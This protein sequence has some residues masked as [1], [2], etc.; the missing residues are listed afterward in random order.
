[1]SGTLVVAD[2]VEG[3]LAPST[4]H[5][6]SAAI[7]LGRP[8][9]L[10]VMS[11][12][13]EIP[14]NASYEGVDLI[15]RA[16]AANDRFDSE[17]A[18]ST[19]HQ[20]IDDT[21]ATVIMLAYSI[22]SATF[23]AAVAEKL[24]LSFASDVVAVTREDNGSLVAIRPVYAGKVHA[25]L[26]M[27]PDAPALL[28]LRAD[29]WPPAEHGGNP[30]VRTLAPAIHSAPRVKHISYRRPDSGVD[31]TRVDIIFALG[32]GVGDQV[33]IEVFADLAK[34][35][36]VGLGA[37][38]PLVDAGWLPAPHQV[39]QTGVTVKPRLYIAFGISGAAQHL[40]GMQSSAAIVAVNS[41]PDAPIFDFADFGAI[42]D[43]N[44]VAKHLR[45]LLGHA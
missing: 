5:L 32:R 10:L 34:Q 30:I 45:A 21:N 29:V 23:G 2:V 14:P 38:R 18:S 28:L 4:A 27:T 36:E 24:D 43:V 33:N 9:T 16:K 7:A 12:E 37:S 39:G 19:V 22:R 13:D 6:V 20:A 8:V 3:R 41:D 35:L 25:E 1:M 26:E 11:A 15:L 42:A 44:E 31:L 40:A 17:F